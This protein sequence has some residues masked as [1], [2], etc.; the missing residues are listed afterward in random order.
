M[1]PLYADDKLMQEV[2]PDWSPEEL[3]MQEGLFNLTDI[4]PLLD[5][6]IR[7]LT[8][9]AAKLGKEARQKMGLDRVGGLWVVQMRVFAPFYRTNPFRRVKRLPRDWT[10]EMLKYQDGVFWLTDVC[11]VLGL[12]AERVRDQAC[13]DPERFRRRG[14][15][16]GPDGKRYQVDIG[17]AMDWLQSLTPPGR[18]RGRKVKHQKLIMSLED[19]EVYSAGSIARYARDSGYLQEHFPD[20]IDREQRRIRISLGHLSRSHFFPES[21]DG[22]VWLPGKALVPGW[23]GS[24]W[25]AAVSPRDQDS[26]A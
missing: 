2:D 22:F 13:Q 12:N 20:G 9:Y 5:L 19:A 21:G 25:K 1:I 26:E 18:K 6:D 17:L 24:R 8:R 23:L 7:N 10:P 3:L 14:I 15:T 4:A 11:R 16:P